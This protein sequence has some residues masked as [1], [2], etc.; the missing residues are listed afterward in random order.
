MAITGD[1]NPHHRRLHRD[2]R[3][4]LARM[5]ARGRTPWV[6]AAVL[7][8][9]VA[10]LDYAVNR[11]ERPRMA[12]PR[13][14]DMN[15]PGQRV[16]LGAEVRDL[17]DRLKDSR[18]LREQQALVR[19][20]RHA[21]LRRIVIHLNRS[22][23][24]Q[25]ARENTARAARWTVEHTAHGTRH[26]L[27]GARSRG[28]LA[29]RA[30]RGPRLRENDVRVRSVSQRRAHRALTDGM[31]FSQQRARKRDTRPRAGA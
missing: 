30:A 4:I 24:I 29:W 12:L 9:Q 3:H 19:E 13:D 28:Q 23:A 22:R 8:A 11:H 16:R 15:A 31:R 1:R 25:A 27:R 5:R 26:V 6:R 14:T 21:V 17:L 2:A 10:A 7:H 20:I 18:N